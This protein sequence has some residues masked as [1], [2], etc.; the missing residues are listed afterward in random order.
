MRLWRKLEVSAYQIA[1]YLAMEVL[2]VEVEHFY[3]MV[4]ER[5][6]LADREKAKEVIKAVFGALRDRISPGGADNLASQLPRELW[7]LWDAGFLHDV[8][9]VIG[10]VDRMDREE[11][12]ARVQNTAH[13]SNTN[14]AESATLAVFRTLRE[15]ITSGEQHSV[16]LQLPDDLKELWAEA[17][18]PEQIV[19]GKYNSQ[20]IGPAQALIQ[21]SDDQIENAVK[22]LLEA[23]AMIDAGGINVEAHQGRVLLKGKV[24]SRDQIE[25]AAKVAHQALGVIEVEN[26]L[27]AEEE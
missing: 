10:G 3:K 16:Y 24:G 4:Q 2:S 12:L 11:F 15:Q 19:E 25:R 7:D 18:P 1:C 21:R 5:A 22:E 23:N 20:A 9:R 13:L 6:G 26:D 14:E 27:E 17:R 8:A